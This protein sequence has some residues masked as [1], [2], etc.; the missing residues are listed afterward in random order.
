MDVLK[1]IVNQPTIMLYFL[2]YF[3]TNKLFV[4]RNFSLMGLSTSWENW[5]E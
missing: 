1:F 2:L 3:L 4:S 5:E